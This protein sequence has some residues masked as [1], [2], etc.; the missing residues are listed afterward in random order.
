MSLKGVPLTESHK[1]HIS[2]AKKRYGFTEE[3]CKNISKGRKG[4]RPSPRTEEHLA[5][6]SKALKGRVVTWGHK[7]SVGVKK[8]WRNPEYRRLQLNR[9][10]TKSYRKRT[11]E[12]MKSVWKRPGYKERTVKSVMAASHAQPNRFEIQ[13]GEFLESL[14]PGEFRYC[15]DGRIFINSRVPDFY[16]K[17]LR[18]VV[19]ANG[20]YW[21]LGKFGLKKTEQNKRLIERIESRTYLKCGYSVWFIWDDEPNHIIKYQAAGG[22]A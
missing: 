13:I 1:R 21:H 9:H 22:R 17:K 10:N 18:T 20:G 11:S 16:S 15:G 5:N 2:I 8:L 12:R 4:V 7:T 6:I 19:E 3:H 14:H